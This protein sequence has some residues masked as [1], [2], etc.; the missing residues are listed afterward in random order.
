MMDE[1]GES[2]ESVKNSL[3]KWYND[4]SDRVSGW[5]KRNTQVVLFLFAL[6]VSAAMNVDSL[7]IAR[8]LMQDPAL[9]SAVSEAAKV[10]FDAQQKLSRTADETQAAAS[11]AEALARTHPED[12]S[13]TKTLADDAARKRAEA[14]AVAL[15]RDDARNATFRIDSALKADS[16]KKKA[17]AEKAE[18]DFDAADKK[19]RDEKDPAM[20]TRLL[21]DAETSRKA[22]DVARTAFEDAESRTAYG[23]VHSQLSILGI[24]LGWDDEDEVKKARALIWPSA[25]YP[26]YVGGMKL[27]GLLL[28]TVALSMGG[29][30]WY[31]VLNN[32]VNVS[33]TGKK[34]VGT[35]KSAG[36]SKK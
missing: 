24:P 28:T 4:T 8:R 5:Y 18:K 30:F 34:P 10:E 31:D 35:D 9:R 14:D 16:E 21:A 25:R 23:S 6:V 27:L 1:E 15:R 22:R 11:A 2:L 19:A 13:R 36:D 12:A 33:S 17:D 20:K 3:K 29:P 26:R 32:L 7:R